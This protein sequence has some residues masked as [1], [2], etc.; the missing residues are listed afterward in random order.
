MAGN[1]APN[2]ITDN[3]VLYLDA[4]NPNSYVSGSTSWRDISRNGVTGSLI[5]GSSYNA[6]NGGAITFNGTNSY[7]LLP[8]STP[9][10]T[11]GNYS[12]SLWLNFTTTRTPASTSNFMIMEAQNLL[13][14]GVDNYL[15]TLS[16]TTV[17]G[18]NGR[19]GFQ[20]FNP[21]STAYTTTNT[22]I[23]GQWYNIVCTY[24][25]SISRQSIY[26]NGIL[27]GS[28]TIANCYFNTNT[29]F[30]LGAYSDTVNPRQW[31]FNGKIS[32]FIVYART[33]SATEILQN[34]NATKTRFS[35]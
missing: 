3:L 30:G 25:I 22:W 8:Q 31:Y 34:Y 24:D 35:L 17:P 27:E 33:L 9:N 14:G 12:F 7:V 10:Q 19:M 18:L 13:L 28:A 1:I 11:Y 23:G 15:Y 26:V 29:F 20:T 2:I 4:A 16:N 5:G 21:L 6:L 32:N